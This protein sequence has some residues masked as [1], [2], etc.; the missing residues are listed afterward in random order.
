MSRAGAN[1]QQ[2]LEANL[3]IALDATTVFGY[4]HLD[5]AGTLRRSRKRH[6]A[7]RAARRARRANR[8]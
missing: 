3:A 1:C 6:A 5:G 7:N 4:T 2:L 8:R